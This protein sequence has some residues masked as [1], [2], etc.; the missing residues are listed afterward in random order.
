MEKELLSTFYSQ[1]ERHK[2]FGDFLVFLKSALSE[3]DE[4]YIRFAIRNKNKLSVEI[5]NRI[6]F[7]YQPYQRREKDTISIFLA[8]SD[9]KDIE[10]DESDIHVYDGEEFV[11]VSFSLADFNL[12]NSLAEKSKDACSEYFLLIK[13][14]NYHKIYKNKDNSLHDFKN[15]FMSEKS[16]D[17]EEW[18]NQ[19]ST[20]NTEQ[21]ILALI[22]AYKEKI[23][24][25]KLKEELYKFELVKKYKGRPDLNENI[26]EEV[27]AIDFRNLTW[28]KA[29]TVAEEIATEFPEEFKNILKDLFDSSI[30]LSSRIF[31]F[32]TKFRE[33][34]TKYAGEE[35]K[36]NHHHN[37]KTISIYLTYHDPEKYTFYQ[38]KY[39]DNFCQLLGIESKKTKERYEH[40]LALIHELVENYIVKDK[41]LLALKADLLNENCYE[42]PKHLILAQDIVFQMLSKVDVVNE[43]QEE[44]YSKETL[45][46]TFNMPINQILYG[47]P[48]TGKTY[49]LKNEYFDQFTTRE[50]NITAEQY[51]VSQAQDLSWWQAIALALLEVNK[52]KVSEIMANRWVAHKIENSNSKNARATIW[53]NLQSHT[54]P[55]HPNVNVNNSVQPFIFSKSSDSSWTILKNEVKSQTPELIEILESVN[56]F[57]PNP[58]KL[59]KRY[60]FTTFHQAFTYEDFIEGIKPKMD[61]EAEGDLRYE[62]QDGVFKKICKRAE[63]DLENDYAIFIDEINRGNVASIFGEL[64]TLIEK[65][66][67]VGESEA[68]E[69]T[70]PYSKQKFSVPNN[71]YIIGTM[72]TAD[73]SVEA[74]DSALRRRFSFEEMMPK[75]ELLSPENMILRLWNHPKYFEVKWDNPEF[76]DRANQ[77]YRFLGSDGTFEKSHHN[78]TDSRKWELDDLNKNPPTL[79]G[80]GINLKDVLETINNRIEVLIDRDHT[81]GHSY[82]MGL[83]C[84]ENIEEATKA[85]FKDKVIPLLQEYFFND[86]GKIQ[87]VLGESFVSKKLDSKNLFHKPDNNDIEIEDY[88]QKP[89]YKFEVDADGFDIKDALK[90]L[91]E[92]K[93]KEKAS[94]EK[95]TEDAR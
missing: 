58:D 19:K 93:Q 70:L 10:V 72:N 54:D 44:N 50:S 52:A 36:N 37:E 56:N 88:L 55:T 35:W 89:N 57:K 26:T 59:I 28:Y 91:L 90:I 18:L 11:N 69:V 61:D 2:L 87:L 4:K 20:E 45:K 64:I 23:R 33:L 84:E 48:G 31:E 25:T 13:D 3:I 42:D 65:D 47:P 60:V 7:T 40:Y 14:A 5:G 8:H 63:K 66:K 68:L 83:E 27:K 95:Q 62:I 94:T 12:L 92:G 51:F 82:F 29:K 1:I 79:S 86:Y 76:R 81:I 15:Y 39:Y 32:S 17:V 46:P 22:E 49:K 67:R 78:N 75:P 34:Y 53:S 38:K 43:R 77:L 24:K 80:K 6:A 73:R 21:R 16:P 85:V 74:L 71:L 9:L 41:E 30:K